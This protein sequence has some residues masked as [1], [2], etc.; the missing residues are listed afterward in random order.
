[1]KKSLK[2]SMWAY[3]M[4][5]PEDKKT[6]ILG[7]DPGTTTT[8]FG[9]IEIKN[10][11]HRVLDYGCIKT[12]PKAKLSTKLLEITED[13]E[14]IIKKHN[15]TICAIEKI[16]FAK[17]I[18]T[19]ITVAHA[20]GALMQTAQKLGLQIHEYA[21]NQIKTAITGYGK[22]E[23]QQVQK[24]IQYSLNLNKLPYPDDAADALAVAICHAESTPPSTCSFAKK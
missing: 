15:P 8:G 18:K 20:R 6:I 24:M 16:F 2:N 12:T 21:P 13:L 19:G 1:M 3:S 23:K 5:G 10:R 7:L 14:K 9:I 17:N 4:R 22:A 11:K